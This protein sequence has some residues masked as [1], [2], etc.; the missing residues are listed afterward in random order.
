[1]ANQVFD[2]IFADRPF[3]Y[4]FILC[5]EHVL[6]ICPLD[7]YLIFLFCWDVEQVL[8]EELPVA[9]GK[10]SFPKSMRWNSEVSAALNYGTFYLFF[11]F[12]YV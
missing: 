5:N 11:Y 9:L 7:D 12:F 1:M 10:I 8:S 6:T 4:P 3:A 2:C